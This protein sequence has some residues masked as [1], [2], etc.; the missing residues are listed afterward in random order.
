MRFIH[1]LYACASFGNALNV[2]SFGKDN[3]LPS[4]E[5]AKGV[6]MPRVSLGKYK[7]KEE[8]KEEDD[9][10]EKEGGVLKRHEIVIL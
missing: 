2:S 1:I 6:T 10:G 4:R 5:I 8:G 3:V 7:E 9:E